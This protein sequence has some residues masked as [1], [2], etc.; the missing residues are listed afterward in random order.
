MPRRFVSSG[1]PYA[2]ID[3]VGMGGFFGGTVNPATATTT[4]SALTANQVRVMQFVLPFACTVRKVVSEITTLSVGGFYGVGLY[5]AAGNRVVTTGA[6][7]TTNTGIFSVTL[8]TPVTLVPGVYYS[9]WTGDN[10]TVILRALT[11]GQTSE[12]YMR[13]NAARNGSAANASAA[14]VLPATLG[15]ITSTAYNVAAVWFEP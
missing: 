3:T 2:Q 8:S 11:T 4:T 1:P 15:T 13:T 6:Q 7:S 14:G 10:T 5:D 9:A 12:T